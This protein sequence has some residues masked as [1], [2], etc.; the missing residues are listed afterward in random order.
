MFYLCVHISNVCCYVYLCMCE[1][2]IQQQKLKIKITA[3]LK[4]SVFCSTESLK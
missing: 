3:Q 1:N 2:Y 4:F